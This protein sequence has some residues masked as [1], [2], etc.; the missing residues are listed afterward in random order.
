MSDE[1]AS[2][3]HPNGRVE[4][5]NAPA[6]GW[7]A[8]KATL[9]IVANQHTVTRGGVALATMNKPGGFDCPGCAWGDPAKPH[10]AE[11]CENGAK[12]LSWEATTLRATP[13]FFAAHTVAQM[14]TMS[15]YWLESHGRLA[16][17]M[18]YDTASDTYQP[19]EWSAAFTVI[20]ERLRALGDPDLA[21][22]YTSG[23]TSNE[24]AFLYQIF[25]REFGT[26]NFPDCSNFCHEPSSVGM[27]ESIGIGKGT[28][29]LEDFEHT[30]AFFTFGQNPGTNSP[31]MLTDL[32][33]MARR[34]VKIV[35]FNPL[36]ERALERFTAPQDPVEMLTLSSTPIA[37]H[38]YQLK[39][40]GDA[41]AIKGI[42]KALLALD[43]AAMAAQQPRVLDMQFIEGHTAGFEELKADLDA[44]SWDN[45][46]QH[47]G[48]TRAQ[49]EAAAKIYAEANAAIVSWGMGITQHQCGTHNV[50]QLVNLLLLRGNIGRPGAGAAPVHGHSNVQGNRTVGIWE[51]PPAEMLD[52]IEKAFN[53]KP[54]RA[55]GRD[56]AAT[57]D[58]IIA[59]RSRA[60]IALGGNFIGASGDPELLGERFRELDL[61]VHI[62]TKLNRTHVNPGKTTLLLPALG[63]SEI[64]LQNGVPQRI[65]VEDSMSMV[66]PSQG[67]L[68]PATPHTRAEPWIVAQ[69]A[70]ATLPN[71][72][73]DWDALI[74]DYDLIR[75]KIEMVYPK[76]FQGFN[77]RIADPRGFHLYNTARERIWK[78]PN[79]KANF[80]VFP[81]LN[82]DPNAANPEALTLMTIRSHDQFNTSI[83]SYTDRY[84]GVFDQRD[85]LF[86]N[87]AEMN[88][89]QLKFGDRVNLRTLSTDG[90]IRQLF[91]IKIVPYKIPDGCCAAYYPEANPL[92]PRYS[93]DS[94]AGT[95]ASKAIPVVIERR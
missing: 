63:H 87:E 82:E 27:P 14:R 34:G 8:L 37:T 64:D 30:D 59:G 67:G 42:M 35:V 12:A 47:S 7:G 72:A 41:A 53:F 62:A 73:V 85:V 6:G 51:K 38:Y 83:Y 88:K 21:D 44:T 81:G 65:T 13:E 3:G 90:E 70:K 45:I 2:S 66:R 74:A 39:V 28:C 25:V 50:Q 31:R 95:P 68:E 19:I 10:I 92:L 18:I 15:D 57:Q 11:F 36:R 76:L 80:K 5:Y 48:L 49:L 20:G 75:D 91:N 77:A 58:A 52:N 4:Q 32:R 26:N 84:R 94:K 46:E 22:F 89:R 86:I 71:T 56:T 16:Q 9:N 24:A 23:R 55:H 54:P 78:T 93:R 29:L 61:C 69:M 60:F 43:D 33:E 79:G 1:S 17:P 40:G